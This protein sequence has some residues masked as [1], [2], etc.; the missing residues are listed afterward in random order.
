MNV[1]VELV[2]AFYS[3]IAQGDVPGVVNLLHPQL[4][5]TEA[6]GFPYYSGTWTRPQ[7]VVE[8]LL[9]PLLRDWDNFSAVAD[10][11]L[12]EGDRVVSLGAYAGV[13]KATGKAM[14]A[15]FAHV[16]R[17]ADGKLKRFDMYT[18]TLLVD[19]ALQA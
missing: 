12:V 4:K 3:A 8:K 7:D 15:P 5:W 19:R 16:W 10:D 1:P 11:F 13:S 2:R 9:A 14:R 18:D 17:V 6:E